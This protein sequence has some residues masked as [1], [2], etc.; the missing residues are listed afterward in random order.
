MSGDYESATDMLH[1]WLCEVAISEIGLLWRI[2]FE[3]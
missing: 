2:P 1:A 3:D